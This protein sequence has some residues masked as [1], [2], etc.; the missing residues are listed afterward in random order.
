MDI[1]KL[2]YFLA[3]AEEGQITKAA[4]RLHMAQPP[5]SQQ[6]KLLES[7]LGI[8]L[9]ERNGGGRKIKLT[10]A[11]QIL[12]NRAEHILTLVDQTVK[13]LK[14]STERLLGTLSVGISSAWDAP[15]LPDKI[16]DFRERYPE[17]D[18]RLMGGEANK[19]DELLGNGMIEIAIAPF[20]PDL[21]TY[22]AIP[23]PD[24]PFVA[25][26]GPASDY[27]LSANYVR[28]AELA[29]KPLIIHRKHETLLEY[30]RLIGLEPRIRCSHSDIRSMLAWAGAGL[31]IAIVPRSTAGLIP[32]NTLII[33]EIVEPILRT[34]TTAVIWL[35]NHQLSTAARNFIDMFTKTN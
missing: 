13:E 1:R 10:D 8:Q 32:D 27:G 30:Y 9:I 3:V 25:A 11:G 35:R 6:L 18:F 22:T 26:L 7:E 20:P 16:R 34:S 17:I 12:R 23:L 4:K 28:L 15:F 14:D 29:D 2:Q 21:E 31:G 24:E 5:L 19:I 33:K